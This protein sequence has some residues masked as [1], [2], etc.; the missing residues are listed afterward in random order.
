MPDTTMGYSD[1]VRG[2]ESLRAAKATL[3]SV[4]LLLVRDH[5]S[6]CVVDATRSPDGSEKIRELSE[7][8]ERLVEG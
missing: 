8:V 1:D 3:N 4:A 2:C 7:A 5:T 6:H